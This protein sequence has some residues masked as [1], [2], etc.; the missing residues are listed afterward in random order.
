MLK[1]LSHLLVLDTSRAY[2]GPFCTMMLAD[3]GAT[4]I[5]IEQPG[6][7]DELRSWG[8]PFLK[9]ES[10]YFLSVNRN[11][12]SMTLDM[13][14]DEGKGIF[15]RLA[16]KADVLVENFRPG[17]MCK[18]GLDYATIG[19]RN[20]SLVY[21]SISAFGQTGPCRLDAGFDLVLQAFSGVMST[22]GEAGGR[23]LKP[24]APTADLVASMIGAYTIMA[25]L[26]HRERTGE[27]RYLDLSM[28][29]GQIPVVA[30]HLLGYVGS[31]EVPG[32]TG[33]QHPT[34]VPYQSFATATHE[35]VVAVTNQKLWRA[36]CEALDLLKL[37][38][39]ERFDTIAKRNVNREALLPILEK[40]FSQRSGEYW[41]ERLREKG[42]PCGPINTIDRLLDH[43][44][45]VERNMM[46]WTTHPTA[47]RIPLPGIA[48]KMGPAQEEDEP[49]PPPLLGEHTERILHDYLGLEPA[50]I[51]ALRERGV[52]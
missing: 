11:K 42:I 2:A 50:E 37:G 10:P 43:P 30:H 34:L 17:V 5:K 21:C 28:M 48:W 4:V 1:P 49:L 39:D 22:T 31:G 36:F 45:V 16:D 18:L 24:G 51:D 25:S 52:I 7:G 20:P 44:Q 14:S 12:L 33:N 26:Y 29:D 35:V 23:P 40:R 38:D 47:G 27:G 13:A 6:T 9:G 41:L 3:L 19:P 15:L 46:L 8:P 32:L